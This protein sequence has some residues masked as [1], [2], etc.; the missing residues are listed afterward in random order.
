MGTIWEKKTPLVLDILSVTRFVKHLT[1][2]LPC[3]GKDLKGDLTNI[4]K[5][6]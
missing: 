3:S 1:Q 5:L 6:K 4:H 2:T